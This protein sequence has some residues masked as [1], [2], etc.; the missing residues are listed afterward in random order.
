MLSV[1]Y[2]FL[3]K[4]VLFLTERNDE[5]ALLSRSYVSEHIGNVTDVEIKTC[6]RF[7]ITE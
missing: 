6:F 4:V 1:I 2:I 3:C 7:R 5:N